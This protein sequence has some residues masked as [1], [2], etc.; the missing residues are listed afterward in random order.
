MK[1]YEMQI[2]EAVRDACIASGDFSCRIA[3]RIDLAAII[4]S[5]PKPEPVATAWMCHEKMENAFARPPRNEQEW[6]EHDS[7]G[8]WSTK[9]Y[10]EKPLYTSPPA[11][12]INAELL[13]ACKAAL[14]DDQPYI[15]KCRA[16]IAKA[17][18]VHP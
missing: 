16:A 2:A 6:L 15:E 9:G 18:G 11:V 12:E 14:S 8:Y 4:A 1:S 13:E 17:E 7:D 5:V 3:E 10:Y